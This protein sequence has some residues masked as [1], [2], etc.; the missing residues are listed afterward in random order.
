MLMLFKRTSV[1][2]PAF[3]YCS[4]DAG[5][6]EDPK[7]LQ[8]EESMST[9]LPIAQETSELN[10][11]NHDDTNLVGSEQDEAETNSLGSWKDG[12]QG[13][14]EPSP[15]VSTSSTV[16]ESPAVGGQSLHMSWADMAQEDELEE[17]DEQEAGRRMVGVNASTGELRI[18]AVPEK[19]KLPRE[20]REQIRFMNVKRNKDFICLERINGK[21]VNILQGLEL[22][23]GVFSAAEQKRI[24]D[25]IYKLQEMGKRGELKGQPLCFIFYLFTF[26][27]NLYVCVYDLADIT[28]LL[29]L[30]TICTWWVCSLF[31]PSVI[32]DFFVHVGTHCMYM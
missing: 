3:D 24:V 1:S 7:P 22:H 8:S 2:W 6:D 11:N 12:T 23:T 21:L 31:N 14:F 13:C 30:F 29:K 4:L 10:E 15:E 9:L 32:F 25:C 18:S 20:Q 17:E 16:F 27:A 19:P 28:V 26:H 5:V